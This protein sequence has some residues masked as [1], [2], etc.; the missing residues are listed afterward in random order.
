MTPYV[1]LR[2]VPCG[3]AAAL[4]AA[5]A[6]V[7]AERRARRRARST[8]STAP[9]SPARSPTSRSATYADDGGHEP[10]RLHRRADLLPLDPA[11]A[12]ATSSRS[13]TTSGAGTPTG[14]GARGPS[15]RRTRCV[16][17]LWPKDRLRVRR[18]LE[19]RRA[20]P[21]YVVLLAARP[22]ARRRPPREQ[23]VQDVE[24][25]VERAAGVPRL[26]PPRGR[27]RA[28]VGVPAA[29]ARPGDRVAAL[30]ARPGGRPTSTSA[31][32]RRSRA[33]RRGAG[34][35]ARQPADRAG[36]HRPRRAQ[37]A[38]LH[39]VLRPGRVRAAVRRRRRT[40]GCGTST[41]RS[42]RLPDMWTKTVGR[43]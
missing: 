32:G 5:I 22:A 35:R 28:G 43:G 2:H 1:R 14:S 15:A 25:P 24:V 8:S 16:R 18:L 26:L 21:A 10:Q 19:A 38:V 17:R 13:T 40:S 7:A 4:A 23:V 29:P 41:T 30:R 20:R 12:P 31:S 37:V 34:R 27:H 33:L 42:G 11:A 39:G 6:E 9:S 36:R 3:D